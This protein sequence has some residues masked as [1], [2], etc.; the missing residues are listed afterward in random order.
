MGSK[1]HLLAGLT[2][3]INYHGL[4]AKLDAADNGLAALIAPQVQHGVNCSKLGVDP[5]MAKMSAAKKDAAALK[6]EKWGVRAQAKV[7][8]NGRVTKL[9][10]ALAR[11]RTELARL[12]VENGARSNV[13]AELRKE[14]VQL[15]GENETLRG[16]IAPLTAER[17]A[18]RAA[19]ASTQDQV[20]ALRAKL[21]QRDA[22]FEA[23]RAK[24]DGEQIVSGAWK[25][26][27]ASSAEETFRAEDELDRLRGTHA[28]LVE[29]AE[30]LEK[31]VQALEATAQELRPKPSPEDARQT[32]EVPE[33]AAEAMRE[34]EV[35]YVEAGDR[36]RV[37]PGTRS[38][39]GT[40]VPSDAVFEVLHEAVIRCTDDIGHQYWIVDPDDLLFVG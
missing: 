8:W 36:V 31:R 19:L 24:F 20:E 34:D 7:V 29:A 1:K 15:Q 14:R 27:A 4:D 22:E 21:A 9:T 23:L 5:A 38:V 17:D 25:A 6:K 37:K 28:K 12:R 10:T 32:Y 16:E 18:L 35:R 2:F 30:L 11:A 26:V 3:A 40:P 13:E 39:V 33:A